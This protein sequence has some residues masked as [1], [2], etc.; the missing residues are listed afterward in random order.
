[1]PDFEEL[2]NR[3]WDDIPEPKLLPKGHYKV[4]GLRIMHRLADP[5][6]EKSKETVT[7]VY[8]VKEALDDVPMDALAELGD[9]YD[10]TCNKLYPRFWI[11]SD[12]DWGKVR[13]HLNAIGIDTTGRGMAETFKAFEGSQAYC[14]LDHRTYK[15]RDGE[16]VTENTATGFQSTA[17]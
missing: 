2:A 13:K 10:L 16:M 8:V 7:P 14:Y 3:S 4:V 6:D 17:A 1:M 9:D 5:E 12:A 11:E 15:N